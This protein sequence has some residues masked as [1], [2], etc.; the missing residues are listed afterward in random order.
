[1]GWS[2]HPS[3][4]KQNTSASPS[5]LPSMLHHHSKWCL[6]CKL[7][8]PSIGQHNARVSR[9][10]ANPISHSGHAA[11]P[12]AHPLQPVLQLFKTAPAQSRL[13][14]AGQRRAN[15]GGALQ[16]LPCRSTIIH[17][18]PCTVSLGCHL[19]TNIHSCRIRRTAG[20]PMD[21]PTPQ[22]RHDT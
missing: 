10:N 13:P 11:L 22:P 19:L 21:G 5:G 4:A 7:R 15:V 14:P 1:M 16:P 2:L 18:G 6:H 3:S 9:G 17:D 12:W 8:R 20:L